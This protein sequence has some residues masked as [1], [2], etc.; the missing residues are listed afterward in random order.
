[1]SGQDGPNLR[2]RHMSSAPK[3]GSDILV[4]WRDCPEE[5]QVTSWLGVAEEWV[6][7]GW[8]MPPTAWSPLG[9]TL[10]SE[11]AYILWQN[12]QAYQ[13]HFEGS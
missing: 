4:F 9:E 10:T 5:I 11:E 3:D 12:S 2:W 1:M 8:N 6:N 7:W 13:E